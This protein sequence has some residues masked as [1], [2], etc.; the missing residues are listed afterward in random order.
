LIKSKGKNI[1]LIPKL[2]SK[3]NCMEKWTNLP[4]NGRMESSP[5]FLERF[6]KTKRENPK[7]D[8]G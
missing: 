1:L 8:T 5:V 4:W 7:K 2:S 6:S 3:I